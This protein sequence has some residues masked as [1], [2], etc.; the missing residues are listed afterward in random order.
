MQLSSDGSI[1]AA[2]QVNLL[3][4]PAMFGAVIVYIPTVVTAHRSP[5]LFGAV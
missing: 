2:V 1:P 3:R 4:S 5:A